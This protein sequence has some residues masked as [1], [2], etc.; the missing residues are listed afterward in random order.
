MEGGSHRRWVVMTDVQSKRKRC[1]DIASTGDKT[2][3]LCNHAFGTPT[4]DGRSITEKALRIDV[5]G[6]RGGPLV[7]TALGFFGSRFRLPRWRL[8]FEFL[9][10]FD[11]VRL[12]RTDAKRG[13][14]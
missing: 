13:K 12:S 5:V 3:V 6:T 10:P 8:L 14:L 7:D 1:F 2:T 9:F 11:S 4:R